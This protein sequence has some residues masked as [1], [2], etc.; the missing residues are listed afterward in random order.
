MGLPMDPLPYVV[1]FARVVQAGG[2]AAAAKS[3][4][5]APSVASKHVS[6][7]EQ[8]LG[9]RLLQRS[10][11]KLSLTEAGAAYYEH[12]AR[13]VEEL[14]Q[15]REA[16]A[17]LQAE[18][19]G[20]LRVSSMM[21]F[22]N[23]HVAPWLPEFFARYPQVEIEIVNTERFVDMAE[24]GFDLALRMTNQP[25][26]NLVARKLAPVRWL[27]CAA[28]AYLKRHGAPQKPEDLLKHEC[29]GYPLMQG[30]WRFSRDGRETSVPVRA[31]FRINSIEAQRSVCVEG[32]G[33]AL[34]PVYSI[35]TELKRGLLVP[36][37]RD[38][39]AWQTSTL[40]AVY[41]PNRYGAPK[42]RAF[43][44]FL[45]EKFGPQP[46]WEKGLKL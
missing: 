27:A 36:V 42:L 19:R 39:V 17:R 2:F 10:T 21:S 16:V 25:A 44:D 31:R 38:Y 6:K 37:L 13:I 11:R 41:L 40:H 28:P 24:E 32:L 15:S 1:T 46:Y 18:P 4:K 20:L 23:A 30:G 7:L 9:A 14:E 43:V 34:L 5:V 12:C 22:S 33:I 3:L 35:T 45:A 26:A 8:S 29:L